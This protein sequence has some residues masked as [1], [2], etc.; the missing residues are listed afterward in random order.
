MRIIRMLTNV[1]IFAGCGSVYAGPVTH[2][3][4]HEHQKRLYPQQP[5]TPPSQPLVWSD[6][7]CAFVYGVQMIVAYANSARISYTPL[8]RPLTFYTMSTSRELTKL[9][10]L[11]QTAMA[12]FSAISIP[13]F[14]SPIT[15]QRLRTARIR[16]RR[17]HTC[18]I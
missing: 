9:Q 11:I 13:L 14:R 10:T 7:V 3:H 6:L 1:G 17:T 18:I 8:V 12:G 4:A 15:G 2:D 16:T 5:L